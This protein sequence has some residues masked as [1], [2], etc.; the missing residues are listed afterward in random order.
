MASRG[1]NGFEVVLC[2]GDGPLT[3]LVD[4]NGTPIEEQYADAAD[5]GWWLLNQSLIVAETADTV[6]PHA[7]SLRSAQDVSG[8]QI[9]PWRHNTHDP[10]R[11]PPLV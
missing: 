10:A 4:E 1:A 6:A 7:V 5:C 3:I 11:A 9:R 8:D 2:T